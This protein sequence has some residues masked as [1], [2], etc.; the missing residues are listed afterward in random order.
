MK[1]LACARAVALVVAGVAFYLP[2][3][4]VGWRPPPERWYEFESAFTEQRP[5]K[6]KFEDIWGMLVSNGHE[7][8]PY[9][10]LFNFLRNLNFLPGLPGARSSLL[11]SQSPFRPWHSD[12]KF[13]HTRPAYAS[14][15]LR[16]NAQAHAYYTGVFEAD[17][18]DYGLMTLSAGF[19]VP[20]MTNFFATS[21]RL[22]R[23]DVPAAA[24]IA[25]FN[26]VS[27]PNWN[28]FDYMICTHYN[29]LMAIPLALLVWTPAG[30]GWTQ[31]F[32]QFGLL[33]LAEFTVTGG[34]VLNPQ[35]PWTLCFV[36]DPSIR[37]R[38]A[39]IEPSNDLIDLVRG[40]R[41]GDVLYQIWAIKEPY[42]LVNASLLHQY[43]HHIGSLEATSAFFTSTYGS[44][45]LLGTHHRF[46][47]DL[48]HR[49]DWEP[50]ATPRYLSRAGAVGVY[51]GLF[52]NP[53]PD[54]RHAETNLMAVMTALSQAFGTRPGFQRL[55]RK[56]GI[57]PSDLYDSVVGYLINEVLPSRVSGSPT[58]G[59]YARF[60]KLNVDW[61]GTFL[62]N[63]ASCVQRTGM[64]PPLLPL[65]LSM[66]G[67]T[68]AHT[69]EDLADLLQNASRS[70][71]H[72]AGCD[73]DA[74]HVEQTPLHVGNTIF[75]QAPILPF[76]MD[77]F[78]LIQV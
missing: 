74:R 43:S 51:S 16:F 26:L 37:T 58:F 53:N 49:P 18:V 14:V 30:K 72:Q 57:T 70:Q 35:F 69:D 40:V 17:T 54:V 3:C 45:R 33:N 63:A 31:F 75:Q 61:L 13:L 71:C 76:H 24:I 52:P 19:R 23:D 4:S 28:V 29:W 5:A 65:Q 25:A 42:P 67:Q 77:A 10:N 21:I 20:N 12:R 59:T 68:P 27:M 36:P 60:K 6:E 38:F 1:M 9:P 64:Q 34:R 15:R 78:E 73:S 55:L 2:C 7:N 50:Y 48:I 8:P 41:P 39:G 22:F 44:Q 56:L 46:E 66:L 32:N 11:Q 47:N 62:T